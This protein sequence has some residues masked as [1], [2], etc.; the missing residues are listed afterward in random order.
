MADMRSLKIALLADVKDFIEGLDDAKKSSNAFSDNLGK[1]LKVA[2]AAFIGLASAAGTAALAIGVSS[3]KAAIEAQKEDALLEQSIK[4]LT[5]ATDAQTKATFEYLDAAE[6][7]AGVNADQLKPSF[8]RILR[9][10]KDLNKAQEIQKVA[11]DV[12]AGTGKSLTEVSDALARAYEGNVKGLKDLGIE[13]QTTIKTTKKVKTSKGDLTKAELSAEAATLGVQKAQE[14]L[15]KVLENSKSDA[16]DVAQAQNALERAQL[17]A[18]DASEIF[19]KKQKNVGKVITETKDVARPF[20]DILK[21]LSKQYEGAAATA[22]ETYAGKIEILK[23]A[24]QKAKEEVGFVLLQ[25]L[26][27]LVKFL[28]TTGVEALKDFVAGLTGG[29]PKSVKNALRDVNGKVVDFKDGTTEAIGGEKTGAFGLGVSVKEL[30][31]QFGFFND[32]ISG[33]NGETG[34]KK[35]IDNL[36]DLLTLI[37]NILEPFRKLVEFSERFASSQGAARIQ[38]PDVISKPSGAIGGFVDKKIDTLVVNLNG[39]LDKNGAAKEIIKILDAPSKTTGIK[40]PQ[41]AV[42]VGLR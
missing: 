37:N 34:L 23:T 13:L 9:T 27:P 19:E 14:R 4:N 40:I 36:T 24:L 6:D 32:E 31:K 16:L 38:V 28:T 20:Q 41:S 3:V 17:R 30:A 12:A 7:A 29:T 33:A 5:G 10:V 8:E 35:L 42:R 22:A 39:V 15:N 11:Q 21:D 25:A 1:A 18:G 26:E 2:G